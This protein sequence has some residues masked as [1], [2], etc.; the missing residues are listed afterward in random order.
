MYLT[1]GVTIGS[2]VIPVVLLLLW[3]K[4]NTFG[5]FLGIVTGCQSRS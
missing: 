2:V 5:A 1:M 4:A 3:S